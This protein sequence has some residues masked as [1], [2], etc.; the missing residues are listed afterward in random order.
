MQAKTTSIRLG[1]WIIIAIGVFSL[2]APVVGIFLFEVYFYNEEVIGWQKV[3]LAFRNP[4]YV[5]ATWGDFNER[6]PLIKPYEAIGFKEDDWWNIE[7]QEK[8]TNNADPLVYY[9]NIG[10]VTKIAVEKGLIMGYTPLID[11]NRIVN[12]FVLIPNK[13]IE[14]GFANKGD[15]LK[16]IQSYGLQEPNWSTMGELYLQ[17]KSTGCLDW[18]PDCK[19]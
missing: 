5:G 11:K 6:I 10:D 14:M 16:Y 13:K 17:F 8:H 18:I 3:F 19:K 7:L 12:W 15:F 4:F 2:V 9:A 1:C